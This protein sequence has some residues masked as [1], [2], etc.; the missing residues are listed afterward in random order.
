M[1]FECLVLSF[2]NIAS[3]QAKSNTCLENIYSYVVDADIDLL[4]NKCGG[5]IVHAVD[6][7]RVLRRQSGRRSH[8]IATMGRYNFLICLQPAAK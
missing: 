8:S 7:L 4:L 5:N 6:A 1:P 3:L 2:W